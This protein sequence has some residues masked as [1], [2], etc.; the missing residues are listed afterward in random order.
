V[1]A[2]RDLGHPDRHGVFIH[3]PLLARVGVPRRPW[4]FHAKQKRTSPVVIERGTS[5]AGLLPALPVP[6]LR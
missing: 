2:R 3:A 6:L 1:D 4:R 5:H